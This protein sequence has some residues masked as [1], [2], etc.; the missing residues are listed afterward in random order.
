MT[1]VLQE[2]AVLLGLAIVVFSYF[3]LRVVKIGK[4]INKNMATAA[5]ALQDLQQVVT[6]L[7]TAVQGAIAELTTLLADIV[8]ANGVNPQQVE[9]T[10]AQARE[11]V[12]NLNTAVAAAQ[13]A[14]NPPAPAPVVVSIAPS[15]A[16]LAPGG[17]TQFV[18]TVSGGAT[19][20]DQSVKWTAQSGQIDANGNYTAPGANGTDVVTAI[21]N[22]DPT[23]SMTASVTITS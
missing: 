12:N 14:A 23:K 21:S 17:T 9:S 13:A 4:E 15:S 16:T 7:T 1:T 22:Q 19:G 2:I 20:G 18:A 8:A 11:L 3:S 10:V 5:G 6:D